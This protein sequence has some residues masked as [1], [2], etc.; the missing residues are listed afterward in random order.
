MDSYRAIWAKVGC[1][2]MGDGWTDNRQRTLIKFL[3]YCPERISFM[4]SIDA[5]DIVKD[6]TNLFQ[7]FGKV[8]EWVGQLNVVHIV[9]DN[10]TNYVVV[11]RLISQKHKHINWSPCA[12]HCLNLIFKN[13]GKMDHV[14]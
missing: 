9:I 13:I 6:A 10:V 2:I 3:M 1:T 5:L 4:K 8:I 7:L 11:G 12:T 14:A